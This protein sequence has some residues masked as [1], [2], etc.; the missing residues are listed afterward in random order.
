MEYLDGKSLRQALLEESPFEW[1]R[2]VDIARQVCQAMFAV[3]RSGQFH[4]DLKPENI[5]LLSSPRTDFVKVVDF[6]LGKMSQKAEGQELTKTGELVGTLHYISPEQG[7][8]GRADERSDIYA[9]ACILYEMVVA[10]TPYC[11]DNAV[12]LLYK[13]ANE[14]LIAPTKASPQFELPARNRSESC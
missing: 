14:P 5:I 2:A 9:L 11:A 8:G 1:Q 3:H 7:R 13:H 12:A 6:G 4:R 10:A